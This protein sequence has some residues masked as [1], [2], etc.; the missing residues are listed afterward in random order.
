MI[1]S[2]ITK[3]EIK[4]LPLLKFE[5]EIVVAETEEAIEQAL[6][7]LFHYKLVGFD[8]ETKPSFK[9]GKTNPLALLQFAIDQKAFLLRVS[10][11][12]IPKIVL[13]F[14]S[15]PSISKV[16]VALDDDF[17]Q[18][19]KLVDLRPQNIVDLNKL[20]PSLGIEKIGVRNLSAIFLNGRVSKNQQTSNW[21][22]QALT[23]AQ[24][25][26]AATD[27]WVCLKI[28]ERMIELDMLR[29]NGR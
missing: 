26:Y 27:A 22:N 13:D 3:D 29:N 23:S 16:G 21:E 20:A 18:L 2:N 24:Q 25:N 9:K 11:A 10:R 8:T 5:G 15:D 17:H 14:I 1:N 6:V 12:G 4:K 28:Y 7:E 19:R